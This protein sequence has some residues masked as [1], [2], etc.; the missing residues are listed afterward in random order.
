[1]VLRL[2]AAICGVVVAFSVSSSVF[3]KSDITDSFASDKSL[4]CEPTAQDSIESLL[5]KNF[6]AYLP[7]VELQNVAQQVKPE[8]AATGPA[9]VGIASTYNP[10]KP[11]TQAGGM[12][13]ASGELYDPK[14]WTAAIHVD[15]RDTFGGVGYGK[16]YQPT[17]ALVERANKR[18]IVKINDVGPLK[19]GR[20]IDF[21]EQTMRYFDPTLE[22]GLIHNV[23]VT[24]LLGDD[25]PTGP[26]AG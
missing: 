11:G 21:N 17:F 7:Y 22:R 23:K 18:V 2:G 13:T 3:A 26:L 24:P 15:L 10:H 14:A 5:G 19:P 8:A 4:K 12:K 9:I 20:I 25:W 1:M 16:N 6:F